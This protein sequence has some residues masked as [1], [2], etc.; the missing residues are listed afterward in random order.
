MHSY[1]AAVASA[2]AVQLRLQSQNPPPRPPSPKYKWRISISVSGPGAPSKGNLHTHFNNLK[3]IDSSD[4]SKVYVYGVRKASGQA[5][6]HEELMNACVKFERQRYACRAGCYACSS[7]TSRLAR[8]C[9]TLVGLMLMSIWA[10]PM[11]GIG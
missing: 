9:L 5:T 11:V 8:Y 2:K 7:C 10:R 1:P 4:A 3:L 6:T